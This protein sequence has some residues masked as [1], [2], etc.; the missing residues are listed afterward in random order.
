MLTA[1]HYLVN[2][3]KKQLCRS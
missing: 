2:V 3:I 1:G